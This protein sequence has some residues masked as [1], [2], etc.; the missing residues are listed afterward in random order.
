MSY[1][2]ALQKGWEKV[3]G[4]IPSGSASVRFMGDV[5]DVQAREK[6][7]LSRSC[8][9]PVK[10]FLSIL[11][12]HYLAAR[13]AG[14]PAPGGE[15]ISFKEL[16][17]GESYYPAFRKRAIEPILHKYGKQPTLLLEVGLRL[18]ARRI[19]QADAA[20][21]LEVFE[22]IEVL[23]EIWAG[24]EEFG[25]EANMLFD[26]TLPLIFCTEDIAVLGGFIAK[27]L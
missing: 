21:I 20:V 6:R 7:I 18:P 15:W 12:L 4:V 2:T 25:P 8:N 17:G 14:L 3:A 5:Y 24:D 1:E 26:R 22:N 16:A 10:D 27:Y 11:L 19:Q 13:T 23:I 9:A